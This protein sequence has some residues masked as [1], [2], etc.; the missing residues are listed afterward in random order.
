MREA[1]IEVTTYCN[2]NCFYCN[3]KNIEK[4]HMD[5][6]L[7]FKIVDSIKNTNNVR[8][9]GTGEPTLHPHF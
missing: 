7:F 3:N 8:L 2:L 5:M 4:K 6:E 1:Q 9:Q